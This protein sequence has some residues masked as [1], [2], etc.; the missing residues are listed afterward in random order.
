MKA[1]NLQFCLEE[2]FSSSGDKRHKQT[3]NSTLHTLVK[4]FSLG[5]TQKLKRP[6][7]SSGTQTLHRNEH[8]PPR[9]IHKYTHTHTH[10][11]GCILFT[12][13]HNT[14]IWTEPGK[15][16]APKHLSIILKLPFPELFSSSRCDWYLNSLSADRR[17]RNPESEV[18]LSAV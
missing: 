5:V 14:R 10:W 1:R 3:N 13:H 11:N 6:N 2:T 7:C 4:S 15:Q 17:K 9:D 18:G 12:Q 8:T 16:K